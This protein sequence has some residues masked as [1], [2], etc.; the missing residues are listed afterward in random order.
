MRGGGR[1]KELTA[2]LEAALKRIGDKKWGDVHTITFTHPVDRA[3]FHRGPFPRPGDGNT[4]YATGGAAD[5]FPQTAGASY[6]Q[7]MDL[8]D[9]DKSVVTNAPGESGDPA[10]K[11]YDNLTQDWL[12]GKYHP[13]PYSRKAVEAAVAERLELTPAGR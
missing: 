5:K 7:I 2:S 13:L 12:A 1:E 11:W 10:S 6:R 4:V 9:W 8:S 3:A